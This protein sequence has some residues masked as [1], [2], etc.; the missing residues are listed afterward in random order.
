MSR[1]LFTIGHSNHNIEK[2]I[3]LLKE[4]QITAIADVRSS[5][6]SAYLSHFNQSELKFYGKQAGINYVFL[7][8]ELGARPQDKSCY[9]DGKAIYEKIAA[10]E[11]FAEG[12]ERVIK[13]SNKYNI[14]LMCAE[15]DP[16]TCHRAV[17]VCQH[18]R[19][20]DLDINHIHQDS[21]LESHQ[22]LEDR[23]LELNGY[24]K[25]KQLSIFEQSLSD[26]KKTSLSKEEVLKEAYINQG[27]KIAYVD[28]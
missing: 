7:G 15:K 3:L 16:I 18:L 19:N 9:V 8:K 6:Y 12:I 25:P 1:K 5:P 20:Y 26:L 10:R 24:N 11:L 17:L 23:L 22:Q 21:S 28:K 13:G 14:A 4:H 2:Y 27:L